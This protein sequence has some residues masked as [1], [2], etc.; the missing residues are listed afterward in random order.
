MILLNR[1]ILVGVTCLLVRYCTL[2][3]PL[4]F[5]AQRPEAAVPGATVWPPDIVPGQVDVLPS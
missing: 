2:S 4:R 3:E 1:V 5:K